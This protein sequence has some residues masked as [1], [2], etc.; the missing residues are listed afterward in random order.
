[1]QYE[2][3]Y[4]NFVCSFTGVVHWLSK[5]SGFTPLELSIRH[6]FFIAQIVCMI[7]YFCSISQFQLVMIMK[8]VLQIA[9]LFTIL[10]VLRYESVWY[11]A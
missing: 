5:G 7:I 8:M 11:R 6:V 1:M 2:D 3:S 10:V 4:F 9:I